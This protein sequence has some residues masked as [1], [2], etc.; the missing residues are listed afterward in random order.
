MARFDAASAPCPAGASSN[1]S[2]TALDDLFDIEDASGTRVDSLLDYSNVRRVPGKQNGLVSRWTVT[3]LLPER[4]AIGI[5]TAEYG[6]L[7]G[8]HCDRGIA[9][10]FSNYTSIQG[11]TMNK[12]LRLLAMGFVFTLGVATPVSAAGTDPVIGTWTLN[13]D[14]SKFHDNRAPK[15]MTRTYSAGASGTDMKATGIAADGSAISQSATFT[16]DGKDCAF[17]GSSDFDTVSLKKV[18]GST[19]KGELKKGGIVVGHA[20]RTISGGGKVLTLS[21]AM[22]TAKGGTT[23]DVAV[24]D[25]Q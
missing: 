6:A 12:F 19:V 5:N 13:L 20:T 10:F 15:S 1:P 24:Y 22:K 4:V 16:Y 8:A 11:E 2:A 25:K 17:T 23:H 18:N 3:F 9:A 7:K 21:T 14:K